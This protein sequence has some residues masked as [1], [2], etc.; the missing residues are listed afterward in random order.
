MT[1]G[2]GILETAAVE[3]RERVSDAQPEGPTKVLRLQEV[4][5]DPGPFG[6]RQGMIQAYD[7]HIARLIRVCP[8]LT[9]STGN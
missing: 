4:Q 1:Q 8:G 7:G 9:L 3:K 2:C 6:E 5:A